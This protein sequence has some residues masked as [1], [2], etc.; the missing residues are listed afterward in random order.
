M[1]ETGKVLSTN[2]AN[3]KDV[4]IDVKQ[5]GYGLYF[6]KIQDKGQIVKTLKVIIE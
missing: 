1:D 4:S 5:L 6:L 3:D 2:E